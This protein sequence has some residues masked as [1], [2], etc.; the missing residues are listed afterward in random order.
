M[1]HSHKTHYLIVISIDIFQGG[2]LCQVWVDSCRILCGE[3]RWLW[4]PCCSQWSHRSKLTFLCVSVH[5]DLCAVMERTV[6]TPGPSEGNNER[7]EG[8]TEAL[9]QAGFGYCYSSSRTP[10]IFY[11]GCL[12]RQNTNWNVHE[13]IQKHIMLEEQF[14]SCDD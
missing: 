7:D 11:Q 3:N 2:G 10:W 9:N 5:L 13:R 8:I 12:I 1:L 14:L 6:F 4:S